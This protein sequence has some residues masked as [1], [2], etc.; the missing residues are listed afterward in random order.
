VQDKNLGFILMGKI[1]IA[2]EEKNTFVQD[3]V[4]LNKD[5]F[6]PDSKDNLYIGF[7]VKD[8]AY[9][10]NLSGYVREAA[11]VDNLSD[12][13]DIMCEEDAKKSEVISD[14]EKGFRKAGIRYQIYNDFKITVYE[15][16]KQTT[17]ADL[18]IL[19]YEVFINHVTG[20]VDTSLLYQILK[21]SRCPVLVIPEGLKEIKNVILT[22]DGK[23]SSVFAIRAF[24]NLFA[25][26]VKDKIVTILTVTP[27]ADEEIKN[28]KSFMELVKQHF[29]NVGM[30][31]LTGSST[32]TEIL[33]FA[34]KSEGPLVIMG[35]YGR[36]MIS[37]L[38]IPSV[39]RRIIAEMKIPLFIAHR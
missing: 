31:L 38:I 4:S 18:L 29:S 10:S 9:T 22:Y 23:E 7:L 28:E 15:L 34:G 35:A 14:F 8:M 13:T 5:L 24:S 37:N 1:L 30:Q 6:M 21:G 16:I 11:M 17:Y 36:S 26:A 33:N 12:D 3:L 19:S 2:L 20:K 32:S 27:S 25:N 39:A